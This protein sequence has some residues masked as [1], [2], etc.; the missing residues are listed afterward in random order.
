[1]QKSK[2][3][4]VLLVLF[5]A[6]F[7]VL[8]AIMVLGN[9]SDSDKRAEITPMTEFKMEVVDQYFDGETLVI[10]AKNTSNEV[11]TYDNQVRCTIFLNGEDSGIRVE[12]EPGQSVQPG[13]I[14]QFYMYDVKPQ[15]N[16]TAEIVMLQETIAYFPER[17]PVDFD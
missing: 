13:E 8:G 17:I 11:W 15:L 14:A 2:Q 16:E 3:L 5:L 9:T 4:V 10:A 1:M 12:L 7:G 6:I